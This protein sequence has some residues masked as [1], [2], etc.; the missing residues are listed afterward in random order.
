MVPVYTGKFERAKYITLKA[1]KQNIE[2][3]EF[4]M[5]GYE[6]RAA[7]HEIDHFYEKLF[8]GRLVSRRNALC[9]KGI[10]SVKDLLV[11]YKKWF[12]LTLYGNIKKRPAY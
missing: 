5:S 12:E 2:K 3:L 10:L 9:V 8:L 6:D 7:Q 4:Q 11:Y 1:L